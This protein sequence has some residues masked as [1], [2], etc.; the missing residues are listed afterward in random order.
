MRVTLLLYRWEFNWLV[1]E[2]GSMALR[3][4]PED[5]YQSAIHPLFFFSNQTTFSRGTYVYVVQIGNHGDKASTVP[6]LSVP[7]R[8]GSGS[9]SAV[10]Y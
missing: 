3:A 4:A 9:I 8:R 7:V 6:R 10:L 5:M 1:A 2:S